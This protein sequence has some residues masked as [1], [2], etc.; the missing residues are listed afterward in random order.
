MNYTNGITKIFIPQNHYKDLAELQQM[1]KK[2]GYKA[3]SHNGNI[4]I[5]KAGI[6]IETPFHIDDFLIKLTE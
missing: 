2:V 3:L 1:V 4:Y 6:W 5:L